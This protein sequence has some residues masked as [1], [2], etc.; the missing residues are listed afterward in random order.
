M[1]QIL[2]NTG[3]KIKCKKEKKNT[4]LVA[5]RVLP[6][7]SLECGKKIS[8]TFVGSQPISTVIRN[9]TK[10]SITAFDKNKIDIMSLSYL[11]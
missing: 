11:N 10:Q 5:G 2:E 9:T 7:Q 1:W 8:L 6:L 4:I 3:R